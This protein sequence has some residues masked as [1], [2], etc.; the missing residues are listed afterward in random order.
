MT[1][2]DTEAQAIR[3]Q[4]KRTVLCHWC[5]TEMQ[6]REEESETHITTQYVCPECKSAG[7]LSN[8]GRTY[9]NALRHEYNQPA[10]LLTVLELES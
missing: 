10:Y 5:G 2:F 6:L 1:I 8:F 4:D 3:D 7:P 9:E